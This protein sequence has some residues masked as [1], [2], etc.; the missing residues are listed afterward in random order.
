MFCIVIIRS[1][2]TFWS[3]CMLYGMYVYCSTPQYRFV[4]IDQFFAHV[5]CVNM[6]TDM[7]PCVS[8]FWRETL[9]SQVAVRYRYPVGTCLAG[10][11][12]GHQR[13]RNSPSGM[14]QLNRIAGVARLSSSHNL[15]QCSYVSHAVKKELCANS[16]RRGIGHLQLALDMSILLKRILRKYCGVSAD[17]VHAVAL[18]IHRPT[19]TRQRR[20]LFIKR[21]TTIT[22][23][24]RNMW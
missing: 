16:F 12:L 21:L 13:K 1:T 15:Y 4:Y 20:R 18:R 23:F 6:Q 8:G 14:I 7:K 22:C 24:G 9:H 2:E 3:P 17:L 10:M 5:C 19:N 11:D